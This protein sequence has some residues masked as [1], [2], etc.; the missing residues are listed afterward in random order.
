MRS[1]VDHSIPGLHVQRNGGVTSPLGINPVRYNPLLT[2]DPD[3]ATAEGRSIVD[4][5]G[6]PLK[7]AGWPSELA[8]AEPEP[9]VLILDGQLE[10]RYAHVRLRKMTLSGKNFHWIIDPPKE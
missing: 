1:H 8:L 5:A 10:G 3:A 7:I 9:G 4:P 2:G 6:K